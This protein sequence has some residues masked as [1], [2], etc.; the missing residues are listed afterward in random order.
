MQPPKTVYNE[1]TLYVFGFSSS[2]GVSWRSPAAIV[3]PE[4]MPGQVRRALDVALSRRSRIP[5]TWSTPKAG[6]CS[7][8]TRPPGSTSAASVP[9]PCS[10]GPS[11]RASTCCAS[12]WRAAYYETAGSS[13]GPGEAAGMRPSG[14][15]ST[16]HTGTRWSGGFAW[17]G[18]GIG[19]D[20]VLYCT[21]QPVGR[22]DRVPAALLGVHPPAARQI[23][24]HPHVGDRQRVPRQRGVSGG[25]GGVLPGERPPPPARLHLRRHDRRRRLA[26][27]ALDGPGHQSHLHLFQR[28]SRP[29]GLVSGPGPQHALPRQ[30]RVVQRIRPG[31]PP[32]QRR[33]RPSPQARLAL[34]RRRLL[35]DLALLGWLRRHRRR[36]TT[37]PPA[38]SS[39]GRWPIS[40]GPCPSGN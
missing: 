16:R 26:R 1:L 13:C 10:T 8:S 25:G 14:R 39:S 40:S 17:P 11:G 21:S 18:N 5:F 30:A 37:R 15:S 2:P 22:P 4:T 32:R 38:R 6:T 31:E 28:A 9:R 33:R 27:P 36:R 24:Q 34:V 35:L 23:C 12:A 7:S 20:V 29:E 3:S 19:L